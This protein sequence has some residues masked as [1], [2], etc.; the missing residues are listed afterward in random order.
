MLLQYNSLS[1]VLQ[2]KV[3]DYEELVSPAV[4]Y[5]LLLFR[6]NQT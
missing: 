4:S 6:D 2:N 3:K 5:Q 1:H